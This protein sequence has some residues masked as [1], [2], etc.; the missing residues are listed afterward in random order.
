MKRAWCASREAFESWLT[1]SC[2]ATTFAST[3]RSTAA[4][5]PGLSLRSSPTHLCTLYVATLS[6]P[7]FSTA[8][9][10]PPSSSL[11]SLAEQFADRHLEAGQHRALYHVRLAQLRQHVM[12][13]PENELRDATSLRVNY[14]VLAHAVLLV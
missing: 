3:S 1:T 9:T 2:N 7:S 13:L 10:A 11:N 6:L 4:M 12:L 5:R 14:P 8:P